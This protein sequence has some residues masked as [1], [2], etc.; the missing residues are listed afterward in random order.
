MESVLAASSS[1]LSS[2]LPPGEY[3]VFLSFRGPDVRNTFADHLYTSLHRSRIRTFRDEEELRKGEGIAPSLVQAIPNSKIYVPILTKQY[4]SSKWCLQELAQMV[5]CW[6]QKKGHLILP[7]FYFV[8]PRDARHQHGSYQEAFEQHARKHSP[9]TVNEWKEALREVGQMKGWHVTES[10]SQGAIIEQIVSEVELHLRGIYALVTDELVGIDSHVEEVMALLNTPSSIGKVVGIHGMGGIGKTSLSK[11]VYNKIFTQFDRSCFLE[12]VRETLTK[13]DGALSLQSKLISSIM[14]KDNH[15]VSNVSE[16]I[17]TIKERVCNHKVLIV[18]DDIDDRFEFDKIIGNLG[19]FSFD[20]RFMFTT[21]SLMK[22]DEGN[23]FWMHDHIKDLGRAIVRE[24]DIQHPYNRSRIWSADDALDMFRNARGTERV[25]VLRVDVKSGDL[26][27]GLKSTDFKNLS[28]LR[29]LEVQYGSIM[30]DFSQVLPNLCCLRLPCCAS[31]PTDIY[32]KKLVVLDLKD[33][34]VTDN[35]KG[36]NR[37]K[38]AAKL[39]AVN[40]PKCYRLRKAPDL[41][42]CTSL[43]LINFES[44]LFMEGELH[45]GNFKNLKRLSLCWTGITGLIIRDNDFGKFRRLEELDLNSTC[46]KELPAGMENLPSLKTLLLE[47]GKSWEFL[48][49]EI[50]RLP[51]SIKRLTISP[52][53]RVPN[54][55]E[56]TELESLSYVRGNIP[57][58]PEDLWLLCENLKAVTIRFCDSLIDLTGIERLESLQEI[59]INC[60]HSITKLP[61]LSSLKNLE[62]LDLSKCTALTEVQGVEGL[63]SLTIL[64]MCDCRLI[65]D[66]NLSGLRKLWQLDIEGCTKLTKVKGLEELDG[67]QFVDMGKRMRVKYLAK[68]AA[69]YG[70][71]LLSGSLSSW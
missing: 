15:Q 48:M 52:P 33:C 46:L 45:I 11:A 30:G 64:R 3:E 23:H 66:L 34:N 16:G 21:R 49:E 60:C 26:E 10:D 57:C 50:P 1:V 44:C 25:E 29:Y 54:L 70:K 8:D 61:N 36:W 39:K 18:I 9:E 32:A 2:A 5:G 31:I 47:S 55:S 43:E 53:S 13:S 59:V 24:E 20:S 56:L 68:S 22:L 41:S 40:L 7:I 28:G 4:A 71:G 62:R 6:K 67:L 69:R 65:K 63:E 51:R 27:K 37:I 58:I 35:W 17:N 19:D 42:T 38:A 12:D 14:K